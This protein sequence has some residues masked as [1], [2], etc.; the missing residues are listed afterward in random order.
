M[1]DR[2]EYL[3]QIIQEYDD[4]LSESSLESVKAFSEMWSMKK[5]LITVCDNGIF[6]LSWRRNDNEKTIAVL[7]SKSSVE[8]IVFEPSNDGRKISKYDKELHDFIE[9]V[10]TFHYMNED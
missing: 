5:P 7:N 2:I 10:S 4:M 3:V 6:H 9:H 1:N 8:Y